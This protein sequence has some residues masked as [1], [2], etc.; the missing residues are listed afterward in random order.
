MSPTATYTVD[1]TTDDSALNACT[2]APNDCSLRGAIATANGTA[3][4]DTIDFDPVV[5]SSMQT[6]TIE[7]QEILIQSSS[8]LT[9]NG[10]GHVKISG[11]QHI[12]PFQVREPAVATLNGL[13]IVDGRSSDHNQNGAAI[14]NR[15]NL[16]VNNCSFSGNV[17]SQGTTG[18]AIG[19]VT[20]GTLTI[21]NSIITGNS[22]KGDQ[23]GGGGGGGGISNGGI[24]TVI[25]STISG[26]SVTGNGS[27]PAD[28]FCGGG[29]IYSSGTTTIIGSIIAANSG[30]GN[31]S[32]IGVYASG[33]LNITNSTVSGNFPIGAGFTTGGGIRFSSGTAN[34]THLTITNNVANAGGGVAWDGG[35]IN[36]RNT[37][38]AGNI[39]TFS[40]PDIDGNFNSLGYNL[41]GNTSGATITGTGTGNILNQNAQLD[42]LQ[43]NGGAFSTHALLGNSPARNAGNNAF[44]VD[45]NNQPLTTDQ[46]GAGFTR[47]VS[48]TV[49]IGAFEDQNNA[50]TASDIP[51]T[52]INEDT[53]TGVINF[54]VADVETPAANLTVT[55]TSGNQTLVPNGNITLGG[56]GAN[57]TINLTPAANQNGSALITVTVTDANGTIGTETFTLTVNPVNARPPIADIANKSIPQNGNTGAIPFTIGDLDNAT[58]SLNLTGGSSDPTLVPIT[59]IVFGGSAANRTVTVTPA[60]GKTGMATITVTVSD[61][62]LTGVDTFVLTVTN[63][64]PTISALAN[65]AT[66]EDTATGTIGFTVGD[67]ETVAGNLLVTAASDNQTL[68]PNANLTLGGSGASRTVNVTPAPNRSGTATITISVFDGDLTTQGSFVLT[69]NAVADTYVVDNMTD[70]PALSACTAAANDCSLR[71]AIIPASNDLILFDATVFNIA[72][73]IVLSGSPLTIGN[74]GM[75]TINGGGRVRV[76]GDDLVRVFQINTGG[77][78]TLNG[79]ATVSGSA[80]SGGGFFNAG[81]L[82]LLNSSVFANSATGGNGAGIENNGGTLNLINTTVSDN[83]AINGSGGAGIYNFGGTVNLTN[84]TISAN[85]AS[86]VGGGI[87]NFAGSTV[88]SRNSI[89]AGNSALVSAPDFGG[90]LNS[91]GYNLIGA[92]AN[93]VITGVTTGNVLDQ[94][95]Q[96]AV[97]NDYGA[98]AILHPLLAGSPALNAGS[99]ALAV[100][101]NN[102]PLTT[103]QR[104]TGFPRVSGSAVDMGAFES[105]G[106]P[107]ITDIID[108]TTNEDTAPATVNFRVTDAETPLANLTITATSGNQTLVPNANLVLGGVGANRTLKITP[109]LNQFGSALITVT[110]TDGDTLT[111]T[112][113]FTLTVNS[114]NDLPTISDIPNTTI[115]EDNA[116]G[117]LAFTVGDVETA[118]DSLII[119][120]TSNNQTIVPNAN[121][122]LGGSGTNRT[123]NVVP[124]PNQ[125][126]TPTITVT[127]MDGNGGSVSD[128][129]L[130]TINPVVDV[131][132]VDN[133]TDNGGLSACTAAA[134]DCSLRGAI[135]LANSTPDNDTIA[136]DPIV[137]S[138]PQTITIGGPLT[139]TNGGGA[140]INGSGLVTVSGNNSVRVFQINSGATAVLNGL[141]I[142]SGTSTRGAGIDNSGNLTLTNST[143]SGSTATGTGTSL[144]GGG[145]FNNGGTLAVTNSV[146]SGNSTTGTNSRGGGIAVVGGTVTITN[147]TISDNTIPGD[148]FNKR[149]GGINS[150]SGTVNLVGSTVSGNTASRGAAIANG[151]TLNVV[152]STISNNSAVTGLGGGIL[153]ASGAV[154]LTNATIAGNTAVSGGGGVSTGGGSINARNSIIAGNTIES[155]PGPDFG[156]TLV[157]QG[158]N[159]IG[160]TTNCTITGTTTGNLL[161][162]SAQLGPLQNNGGPTF[163]QALLPASPAR[164]A[165]NDAL[166]LDLNNQPLTTDQRGAG[167]VRRSFG[168]VDMGAYEYNDTPIVSDLPNASIN[169][170]TP[171]GDIGFTVSDEITPAANLIVTASSSNQT[172]VPNGNITLGGSGANHTL[173]ISPV[174]NQFGTTL[175]TVFA[176]D[177]D[178]I[179]G[180]DTFTL[181]VN[182]VNDAPTITSLDNHAIL[183]D[184]STGDI[185]FTV[186][187]VETP[188][189]SLVVSATSDNQVLVPNA[190]IILGGAGANRTINITPAHAQTGSTIITV[191]VSDG[192]LTQQT[193]FGVPVFPT[194]DTFT[195]DNT[196]DNGALSVCTPAPGD[197]SLRGA[198]SQANSSSAGNTI[199]FDATVFSTVQT[200]TLG[201]SELAIANNGSLAINEGNSAVRITGNNL[202][203]VFAVNFGATVTLN[204]LTITGGN[205]AGGGGIS[206]SG[207]LTVTNSTISGNT[208]TGGGG[209]IS[210]AGALT[211]TTS[212]ISGNSSSLGGGLDNGGSGNLTLT[213]STVSGNNANRPG[214]R[215]GGGI[216]NGGLATLINV[217][218]VGNTAGS[219]G[220]GFNNQGGATFRALNS[221]LTANDAPLGRDMTGTLESQGF[222][223]IGVPGIITG[224]TNGNILNQNPQLL[225]LGN[226][227]GPTQTHAFLPNSPALDAGV[228]CVLI[229]N[230]CGGNNPALPTDQR[231]GPRKTGARVDI[232]AFERNIIFNQ[233]P[234]LA[235]NFM[236]PYSRQLDFER[237]GSPADAIAALN[238]ALIPLGGQGLPPGLT[239]DPSGLLHGTPTTLGDYAFTVMA[240]DTDGMFGVAQF[241]LRVMSPTNST[242]SV[243]G[244]VMTSGGAGLRNANV[245]LTDTNGGTRTALTGSFGYYRFNDVETGRMYV[246]SI[247]S[248]RFTFEPQ[249]VPVM[250]EVEGLNFTA[251]P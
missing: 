97:L 81:T 98:G 118:V 182:S 150:N 36:S 9:I 223:L 222:N 231:G 110:V 32:G 74:G 219:S 234:T 52:T 115:N 128:N 191:V 235:A 51:N 88:N 83:T 215:S 225:P 148:D 202:S 209:G 120:A 109:A 10:G 94:N 194:T 116:T 121:I 31:S 76:S 180:Y 62:A 17:A 246:I 161:N 22:S 154:N 163:T 84:A 206:N 46:R 71:G 141:T 129:F 196:T 132:L 34:L 3:A 153:N 30:C 87:L 155:G 37:I 58:T 126:G 167:F 212:T 45:S 95:A 135:V 211:V 69:V 147:S 35:T 174:L 8:S 213:N 160:D 91:Q 136:F 111:A 208:T 125:F 172:L 40:G 4:N 240:T 210:N 177:S 7:I 2:A 133:T 249:A 185:G 57:R 49:D 20:F 175:I 239:L 173:N 241:A 233:S 131:F 204:G 1:N 245:I 205:S 50:P 43:N 149:G 179:S 48:G 78:L 15:G 61:G 85:T 127:V 122:T 99:N 114:V 106:V 92:T 170:D 248:K 251:S 56:S 63:T 25:N 96:L 93:T 137:F 12:R 232:G 217:T 24:L 165:G 47:I 29:G 26:N 168:T 186:G 151:G 103:D 229:S 39:G 200:I 53:A 190:N 197:C 247:S 28:G 169:E 60:A 214:S 227:G 105:Q 164:N 55:A 207:T 75:V 108:R 145:I 236:Q 14:Y 73:F 152:N 89:I 101:N 216:N 72:P 6:I 203:R 162:Q 77:N 226:Y 70:N 21:M 130:L 237:L 228:D 19:N 218:L 107:T 195:V 243:S 113:T 221:M 230:S 79:L 158:Y 171:T 144:G 242:V 100:D 67:A 44:A 193:I 134:N 157:S 27:V 102:Q 238:I 82:T 33:T 198:I 140:T 244:R 11:N 184:T 41:I 139:L 18:G 42:V 124:A 220:G 183:V 176:T 64:A 156:G 142:T 146:V 104:G 201:G 59:N 138:A 192:N 119:S 250:A 54:T 123:I 224:N 80:P 166:A 112:D 117:D 199:L 13:T 23:F 143:V 38:I 181:T 16:T 188:A 66:N 187:D 178:G 159:L 189:G 68:A 65:R 86:G 5:F 90:T